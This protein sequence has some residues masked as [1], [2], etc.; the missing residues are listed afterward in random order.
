VNKF[1]T[2]K[3]D[4]QIDDHID[5]SIHSIEMP[6]EFTPSFHLNRIEEI[7]YKKPVE[8]VIHVHEVCI[9]DNN[10]QYLKIVIRDCLV[11]RAHY[12]E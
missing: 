10:P 5:M 2:L 6:F 11:K 3:F 9:L 12:V 8:E 7:E 4:E 1:K